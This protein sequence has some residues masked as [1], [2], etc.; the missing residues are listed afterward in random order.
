MVGSPSKGIPTKQYLENQELV[1]IS[2]AYEI[3]KAFPLRIEVC[4]LERAA[5]DDQDIDTQ[6]SLSDILEPAESPP[7]SPGSQ[8]PTLLESTAPTTPTTPE[9]EVPATLEPQLPARPKINGTSNNDLLVSPPQPAETASDAAARKQLEELGSGSG[10]PEFKAEFA[11][12]KEIIIPS[13]SKP[14]IPLA[15]VLLAFFYIVP[16]FFVSVFFTSSFM[17]EKTNRKLIILMS[18]PITPL[19]II[20]GKMLPYIGYSILAIIA[21][22]LVLKG[23]VLLAL[24]IFIPIMLF[25]FSLYLMVRLAVSNV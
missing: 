13:L 17:E 14:P 15:Q 19:Q 5:D 25:I 23:N 4:H 8:A 20:L 3:D 16:I 10:L 24:A 6:V 11:S 1:R 9:P 12:D 18:A 2:E 7:T 22:T 21:I